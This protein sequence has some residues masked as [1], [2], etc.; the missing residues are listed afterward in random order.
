MTT[1]TLIQRMPKSLRAVAYRG[2]E[3]ADH[4]AVGVRNLRRRDELALP[5]MRLRARVGSRGAA[6]FLRA[7][8]D[9]ADA[10]DAA[11]QAHLG[12]SIGA[13]GR[14]LD[15]GCGCGRTLRHFAPLRIEGCDV[16]RT[17]IAWLQRHVGRQ[18]FVV[19][20]FSPPLPFPAATFDLVYSVSIFTHLSERSQ[21]AWLQEIARVLKPGAGALL[22]VQ[23][24]H[25][26][27]FFLDGV[28][29]ISTSMQQ[30]IAGHGPLTGDNDFI[31]EPYEV[32]TVRAFPGVSTDYGLTFQTRAY[33]D[34]VWSKHFEICGVDAGSVDGLQDVVALRRR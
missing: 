15:F 17:A 16:D 28:L 33:I 13:G 11:A 20:E 12:L 25:A 30:R 2:L 26:L 8:R 21:L 18:R 4:L 22:T 19:N 10:L 27:P 6:E 14:T 29:E 5:P 9:C 34:R 1:Q 31:F 23:S 7:G 32:D 24:E 3:A